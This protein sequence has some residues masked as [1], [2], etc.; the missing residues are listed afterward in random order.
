M[1]TKTRK[2][3]DR[4]Q[5]HGERLARYSL[6]AAGR[7]S[8]VARALEKSLST[9]SHEVSDRCNPDLAKA[10]TVFLSLATRPG[11][12]AAAFAQAVLEAQELVDVISAETETLIERG[13]F[14]LEEENRRDAVEDIAS[15]RG[16]REH[17]EALRAHGAVVL[18]LPGI[19][20]ELLLRNVDLH[21]V[22]RARGAAA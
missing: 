13:L 21:E 3:R 12:S 10:F 1:D 6:A 8:D 18:E 11:T 5:R 7:R 17:A 15:L 22:Y 9:I 16:S 19:I 4:L 2:R 14:L 20:D